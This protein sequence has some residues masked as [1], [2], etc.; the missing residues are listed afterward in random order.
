MNNEADVRKALEG[1]S[2]EKL[3]D[4]YCELDRKYS[5]LQAYNEKLRKKLFGVK[6][7]DHIAKGQLS[8]FNEIEDAVDNE[9]PEREPVAEEAIPKK[10]KNRAPKNTKLKDVRIDEEHI[11]P[12]DINCPICGKKMSELKRTTIDYLEYRPAEYVLSP[13]PSFFA[14]TQRKK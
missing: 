14:D 10:K 11:Y 2:H 1:L 3:I 4:L 13:L 8:L 7:S 9:E 12:D 6:N 5:D